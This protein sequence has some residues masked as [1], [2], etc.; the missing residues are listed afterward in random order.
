MP[1]F[2]SPE[3]NRLSKYLHDKGVPTNKC[4][5]IELGHDGF[6]V[7]KHSPS[8]STWGVWFR[9]KN[10]SPR[11]AFRYANVRE[12]AL[13]PQNSKSRYDGVKESVDVNIA[14]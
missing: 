9:V 4:I 10:I 6:N 11:L 1:Y 3:W 14:F 8:R 7:F 12:I 5:Y 13:Y 2:R